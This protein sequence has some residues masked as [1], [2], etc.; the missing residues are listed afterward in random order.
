MQHSIVS[1]SDHRLTRFLA[2]VAFAAIGSVALPVAHAAVPTTSSV[3]GLLTSAGGGAAADGSYQ[4]TFALY[5]GKTANAASWTEG[6]VTVVVKGGQFSHRLGTTKVLVPKLL[7]GLKSPW[8]G[9]KVGNDPEL[10]RR[11][12]DAIS[13][14]HVAAALACTNCITAAHV[15]NGGIS[16]AKIGFTYAG[17]STKGG[18]ASDLAC[19]GCVSTKEIKFDGDIDL[20]GSSLKAKN[21]T[22][23]G[24]VVANS[25][26]ATSFL[27]DG[28]K[29]TGIKIPTGECKNAGEVVKGINPDGSLKCV[30]ALDP[31]ALPKDGIDEISNGLLNNQFVDTISATTKKIAIPDN[32][33]S[34]AV[35]NLSFPDIGTTQSFELS[36]HVENTNLASIALTVLPPN[37]KKVGYTL[38]DPCGAKDTKILKKTW[39]PTAKPQKGDLSEWVGKN[40]VGLWNLKVLDSAFC[41]VQAPGNAKYCDVQ[42]KTDGWIADWSIK[43]Q[44]LSTKKVGV[45]GNLVL[46]AATAP[47]DQFAVGAVKYSAA[48]GR[49]QVCDGKSWWP[50][51]VGTTKSNAGLTC[52]DIKMKAPSAKSGVY[53]VDP[54][55]SGSGVA[56]QAYCDQE[57]GGGGWTLVAKVKGNDKT[58]N[59]LNTAQW[60]AKKLIGNC[61]TTA[62]ENA[63]CVSYD[64]VGFTDVMIRSLA[65]PWRNLA[66]GHRDAYKSVWHVV[67]AGKRVFTRNRLFGAVSNLDYNGNPLYHRDCPTLSY[68]FFTGDYTYNYGG[69]AGHKS[70][71]HGHSGGVVGASLNDWSNWRGTYANY[72]YYTSLSTT[73]CLSDF[74]VGGGYINAA[75]N[76]DD[77]YAI[78]GH[79]WGNGN[80]YTHNWNSHGVFVR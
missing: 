33:G 39:S 3:E 76:S 29:L 47:C 50:Q 37:D 21:G 72:Y 58:M 32:Q 61:T 23:G 35:S 11:P 15:A 74:A 16:A 24:D 45:K 60:R 1:S 38:C 9:I 34:E 67:E 77:S 5:D 22:F 71:A 25:F 12:I 14:A 80:T 28:S 13:Y 66:W 69:I 2:T 52:K 44:T 10:P 42:K 43:I 48:L 53:W 36:V 4:M 27:G 26:T 51:L 55:G 8:L 64:K 31:K 78:N 20:G 59:R 75:A 70:L 18:P 54:D 40:P 56:F 68:G 19:T 57:T 79:W 46:A 6:P 7:A 49:V 62:S 17:S 73:E 41:V 63:L 30:K 65:K